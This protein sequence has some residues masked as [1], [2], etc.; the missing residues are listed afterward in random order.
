[1]MRKCSVLLAIASFL[2]LLSPAWGDITVSLGTK[3]TT[4]NNPAVHVNPVAV[5]FPS[6]AAPFDGTFIGS[7][8][9]GPNFSADWNF[10]YVVPAFTT[11]T[12]ASFYLQIYDAD[13]C[14][15]TARNPVASFTIDGSDLTSALNTAFLADPCGSTN[16]N[17]TGNV[18]KE[19]I[20]LPSSLFTPLLTSP[21]SVHL[22]LADLGRGIL[23]ADTPF[24]G[25]ELIYSELDLT[26]SP[27][28]EPSMWLPVV[29]GI[30]YMARRR[31]FARRLD[32]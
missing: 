18:N 6:G 20:T 28:P 9:N 13:V 29:V 22:A 23:S 31:R 27:V 14:T 5:T 16:A 30:G 15:T 8:I 3:D 2:F 11:I 25:A 17:R 7:D 1:M 12:A 26:T 10:T 19:L 32:S 24:N 21:A 4:N